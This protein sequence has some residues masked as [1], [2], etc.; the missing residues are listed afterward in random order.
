[1]N[2]TATIKPY[3]QEQAVD[4]ILSKGY[5]L[6]T[7]DLRHETLSESQ[8]IHGEFISVKLVS[9]IL[10]FSVNEAFKSRL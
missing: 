3:L 2:V 10:Y 4:L 7:T 9:V 5:F 6:W 8:I 1:M